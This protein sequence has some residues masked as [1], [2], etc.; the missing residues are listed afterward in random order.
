MSFVIPMLLP[1]EGGQAPVFGEESFESRHIFGPDHPLAWLTNHHIQAAI[2][3]IIVISFWLWVSR[4]QTI[5]PGK[6]QYLG[7]KIYDLVRQEIALDALG[8]NFGRY[9]NVVMPFLL[10][11]F[12]F[13]LVNNLFG[14]FFVFMFPTF[15][16]I[17]FAYGLAIMSFLLYNVLGIHAHGMKYFS[18]MTIPP[19]VPKILWPLIIPL[20]ILSNF[21]TRPI[22]LALRLFANLFGGHL[23]ILVLVVGGGYLVQHIENPLWFGGGIVSIIFSFA[24]FALELLVSCLQAFVFTVLTAQYVGSAV[25]EEH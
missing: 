12:S 2:G 18:K 15:S 24:V 4:K 16:K 23:V 25:S 6:R 22:A 19:G 11:I 14:E 17:G 21:I 1:L 20:E 7:E 10:A 8:H 9:K 13:I 5:V 3:A